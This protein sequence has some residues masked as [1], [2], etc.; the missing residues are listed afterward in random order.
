MIIDN[1]R[2]EIKRLRSSSKKQAAR[3]RKHAFITN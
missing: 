1:M 3:A 2:A